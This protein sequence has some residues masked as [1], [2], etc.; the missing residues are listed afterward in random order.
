MTVDPLDA[1]DEPEYVSLKVENCR[2][3]EVNGEA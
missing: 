2:V 1:P 3:T